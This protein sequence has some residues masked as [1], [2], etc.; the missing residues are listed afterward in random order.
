MFCQGFP[1]VFTG[2]VVHKHTKQDLYLD[3]WGANLTEVKASIIF[4]TDTVFYY[5][6]KLSSVYEIS[7]CYA[8]EQD[9]KTWLMLNLP[10]LSSIHVESLH[11][12]HSETF[13]L[14]TS[15]RF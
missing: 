15:V 14:F 11:T 3:T 4:S 9:Y 7:R 1:P 6:A 5:K 8:Q 2:V 13:I 10:V 12:A